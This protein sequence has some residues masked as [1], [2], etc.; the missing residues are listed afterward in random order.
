MNVE[1]VRDYCLLKTNVEESSPFGPETLVFK[2]N[3]KIFVLLPI[4][5]ATSLNAKCDP[6]RAIELRESHAAIIPG[7]HMSK[8]H[9]NTIR[10]NEDVS[11]KLIFELIDHSYSLVAK[12]NKKQ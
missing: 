6:E 12:K 10:F 1:A 3:G 2:V 4:D 9:W 8:K 7:F 5:D 11:D